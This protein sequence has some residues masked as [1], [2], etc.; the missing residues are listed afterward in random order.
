MGPLKPPVALSYP[1][2]NSATVLQEFSHLKTYGR[3]VGTVL[4][5]AAPE[6]RRKNKQIF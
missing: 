1:G 3:K 5:L 6:R 4:A 2:A